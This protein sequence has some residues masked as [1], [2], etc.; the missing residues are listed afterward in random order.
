ME[1]MPEIRVL[2]Q[3]TFFSFTEINDH[4]TETPSACHIIYGDGMF[5]VDFFIML[6]LQTYI[7]YYL[8]QTS[9]TL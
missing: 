2:N 9:L 7:Y 6:I 3:N 4:F 8:S 5:G 1:K